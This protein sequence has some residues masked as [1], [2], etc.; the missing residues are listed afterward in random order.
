MIR[1]PAATAFSCGRTTGIVGLFSEYTGPVADPPLGPIQDVT[2]DAI[3]A[4][5]SFSWKHQVERPQDSFWHGK[6]L[7]QWRDFYAPILRARGPQW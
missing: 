4:Q 3:S 7:E 2:L 1:T 5:Y 6:T